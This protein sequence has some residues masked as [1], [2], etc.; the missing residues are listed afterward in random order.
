MFGKLFVYEFKAAWRVYRILLLLA[1]VI[2][3]PILILNGI[4]EEINATMRIFYGLFFLYVVAAGFVSSYYPLFRFYNGLYGK[5]AYFLHSVPASRSRY[6][7]SKIL[8]LAL[9]TLVMGLIWLSLTFWSL[10]GTIR[11]ADPAIWLEIKHDMSREFGGMMNLS[12]PLIMLFLL[13]AVLGV[14]TSAY[15]IVRGLTGRLQRFGIGGPIIVYLL[16]QLLIGIV[17]VGGMFWL[18]YA[19]QISL[20]DGFSATLVRLPDA[21]ALVEAA[22]TEFQIHLSMVLTVVFV[23]VFSAWRATHL[24]K[25]R[26]NINP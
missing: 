9:W 23:L 3:G 17:Q 13:N 12:V 2:G 1:L 26:F 8:A 14:L 25:R 6:L 11:L 24:F 10:S 16:L 4:S 7:W 21:P 19:L 18:P 22:T 20:A 15:V 5:E